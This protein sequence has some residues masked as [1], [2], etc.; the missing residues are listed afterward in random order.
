M[1]NKKIPSWYRIY[2]E[3]RLA[4][5]EKTLAMINFADK[6]LELEYPISARKCLERAKI[7]LNQ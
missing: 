1:S 2:L 6:A 3:K 7:I 4:K 5:L